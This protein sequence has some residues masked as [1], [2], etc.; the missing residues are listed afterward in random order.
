MSIALDQVKE[1]FFVAMMQGYVGNKSKVKIASM[2][3]FKEIDVIAGL[4]RCLDRYCVNSVSRK[5]AG[6]TT[7]W[8]ENDPVWIMNYSG[9]Y[10]ESAIDFLKSALRSNYEKSIFVGGRG[11]TYFFESGSPFT[12]S[13]FG[14]IGMTFARFQGQEQINALNHG[15]LGYHNYW[16]MSLLP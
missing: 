9:W 14:C 11:P 5:S 15:N 7:I 8:F 4:W 1:F 16:G 2:P 6:T 13:N 12:Y 10:D 3:G